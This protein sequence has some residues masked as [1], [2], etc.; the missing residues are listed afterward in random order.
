[1]EI[2][3]Q[4]DMFIYLFILAILIGFLNIYTYLEGILKK[5]LKLLHLINNSKKINF[6]EQ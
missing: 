4:I 6:Q 1:M 5:K 3:N 2:V